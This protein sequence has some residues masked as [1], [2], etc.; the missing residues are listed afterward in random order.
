MRVLWVGESQSNLDLARALPPLDLILNKLTNLTEEI[1]EFALK[2][3]G[4]QG[5]AG[6][7]G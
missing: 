7:E 4:P 3:G 1:L 6:G 2:H 5:P